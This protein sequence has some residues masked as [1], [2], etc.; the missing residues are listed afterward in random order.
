[1]FTIPR[2]FHSRVRLDARSGTQD[3]SILGQDVG[4]GGADGT[5]DRSS[6][7]FSEGMRLVNSVFQ[8]V[9]ASSR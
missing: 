6:R 7:T 1:M 8:K 3:L 4:L 5:V 2:S 9:M